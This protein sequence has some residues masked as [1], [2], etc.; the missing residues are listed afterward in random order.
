MAETKKVSKSK[1]S[2]NGKAGKPSAEKKTIEK[3]KPSNES[4]HKDSPEKK[5]EKAAYKKFNY[6]EA[7]AR[8]EAVMGKAEKKR[9]KKD[10]EKF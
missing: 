8:H 9:N 4:A 3:T 7:K 1:Q 6:A 5:T 10:P 2:V